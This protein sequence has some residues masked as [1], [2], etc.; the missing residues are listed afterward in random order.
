MK[1][2]R[3][4]YNGRIVDL[5][6][7]IPE[8]EPVFLLRA[9]DKLAPELLLQWAMKLRLLGGDPNM[10]RL[11]EDHAQRMI[12]WQAKHGCKTPDLVVDKLTRDMTLKETDKIILNWMKTN[13]FN[14][15]DFT[16]V[17][18]SL[19]SYCMTD[20]PIGIVSQTDLLDSGLIKNP[21]DY[22]LEDFTIDKE[23]LRNSKLIIYCKGKFVKV[24]KYYKQ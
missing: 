18:E 15:E 7:K 9:Q 17:L 6:N 22:E 3:N 12:D 11:A 16:T 8:D 20:N 19:Q 4:D 24:L 21:V 10:A 1:H 5:Q 2:A 23:V 13:A 14:Q